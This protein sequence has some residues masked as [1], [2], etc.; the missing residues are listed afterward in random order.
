MQC[1]CQVN[2]SSHTWITCPGNTADNCVIGSEKGVNTPSDSSPVTGYRVALAMGLFPLRC[3][4]A[5]W[6]WG[7]CGCGTYLD[8]LRDEEISC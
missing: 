5:G 7:G 8:M 4:R 2:A 1:H 6:V 3:P